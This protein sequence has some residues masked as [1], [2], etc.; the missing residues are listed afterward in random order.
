MTRRRSSMQV[1]IERILQAHG[2]LEDFN[3][4]TEFHARFEKGG[5]DPLVIERLGSERVS[6]AHYFVQNGDLMADPDIVFDFETWCPIEITQ[7]PVGVY[8]RKFFER[9]GKQYVDVSFHRD[10]MALVNVW[11][12]NLRFQAWENAELVRG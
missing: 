1:S 2:L 12:K 4:N 11:A 5:Y 3:T 10:V 7:A 9:N 8:R 6:V